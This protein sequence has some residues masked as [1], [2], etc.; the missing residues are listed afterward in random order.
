[1]RV[2][3]V[4]DLGQLRSTGPSEHVQIASLEESTRVYERILERLTSHG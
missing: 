3:S 4:S 1:M 2:R